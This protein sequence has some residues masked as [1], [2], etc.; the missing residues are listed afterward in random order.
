[1]TA[2]STSIRNA[3][4]D[5]IKR[6]TVD[7]L[8]SGSYTSE[9]FRRFERSITVVAL[10]I[11]SP[12]NGG[13]AGYSGFVRN[14]EDYR[15]LVN[16]A[17]ASFTGLAEPGDT[18]TLEDTDTTVIVTR[19]MAQ[20]RRDQEHYYTQMG[21]KDG[22]RDIII[23]NAPE[24]ALLPVEDALYGLARVEP[25]A[26]M[27]QLKA[28]ARVVDCIDVG[29]LLAKRNVPIDFDG[30]VTL[31]TYFTRLN[32]LIATLTTH[33]VVTSESEL[34]VFLLQ[35]IKKQGDFKDDVADWEIKTTANK[36]YAN[37][38]THFIAADDQRRTRNKYALAPS[39]GTEY[40]N[41]AIDVETLTNILNEGLANGLSDIAAAADATIHAAL[42]QR[43][44]R[45]A[46][47]DSGSE[48]DGD[49]LTSV[50]KEL[51]QL[52]KENKALKRKGDRGNRR[53]KDKGND[54]AAD[55]S[56]DGRACKYCGD[57]PKP[58]PWLTED[59]CFGHPDR[60]ANAPNWW[61]K[62]HNL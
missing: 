20:H 27:T 47:A 38:R 59:E 45:S 55:T 35:Q 29:E 53:G 19:K 32:K 41:A 40:A 6:G 58:H 50:R 7:A 15:V 51:A 14:V 43:R 52:R 21:A 42:E 9:D 36:T 62:H 5:A 48:S 18:P 60:K 4:Y 23:K 37:F 10:S 33:K 17:T 24:E 13:Q 56:Y 16:N 39:R 25:L 44:G 28:Y 61:K 11:P 22:L 34:M 49:T 8:P 31:R 3:A 26:L 12:H 57:K 46:A 2:N 30:E 54:S 1:M